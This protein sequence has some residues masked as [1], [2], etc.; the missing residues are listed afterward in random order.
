MLLGTTGV[1]QAE[2]LAELRAARR[3][4]VR[5]AIQA[6]TDA[7]APFG[8]LVIPVDFADARF[9]PGYDPAREL[10]PRLE[11][12]EPGSLAH[13][14]SVA[15]RGRTALAVR[16]AP[17]VSLPEARLAYSDLG[18]QG[19]SRTRAMAQQALAR[20]AALGADFAAADCDQDGEVD[21][22]L[23]LHAAPGL[24]NDPDGLIVP[25]QYFLAEPVVQQGIIA[26]S[27][28]VAAARSALGLWA[29]ETGHLLGLEDRYD[30]FFPSSSEAAPRGGLGSFSL[31]ASGWLGSGLGQDPALP[32]AY[33]CLLL[34]WVDL[35]AQPGPA[36]V[37]RLD[38]QD[39]PGPEFFLAEQRFVELTGPYDATLPAQRLLL[40]HIDER[41]AEGQ[42]S[43]YDHGWPDRHLRA[44]LVQ[45]D[46]S[47][48]V[49]LGVSQGQ[50]SDLFPTDGQAQAFNDLTVP[51]SRSFA[52][53]VTGVDF[54]VAL[55]QGQLV[56]CQ[57][58]ANWAADFR[59]CFVEEAGVKRAQAE[60]KL[61]SA[62]PWPDSLQVTI[63]C[64]DTTWGRFAG[65]P[66]ITAWLLRCAES[67]GQWAD[68]RDAGLPSW[69]PAAAVPDSALSVFSY[70]LP[71]GMAGS[72]QLIWPWRDA[73]AD[74]DL[75]GA[76]PG[77]W[78]ATYPTGDSNTRWHRWLDGPSAERIML[79]CTAAGATSGAAW[80]D[81]QYGNRAHAVLL[82][83]PLG[84]ATR[85]IELTHAVDLELQYPRLAID[86]VALTW[87]HANGRTVVPAVPADGWLGRVESR[88]WHALAGRPTFAVHDSLRA[89]GMPLWRREVLP[90]PA[91][92]E[93]GPGPWQLQLELASNALWRARGWLVRDLAAH[94]TEAPASGFPLWVQGEALYWSWRQG[95]ANAAF[96]LEASTDGGVT[97]I[98]C[99]EG[100]GEQTGARGW[101]LGNFAATPGMRTWLR[102]MAHDGDDT[103]VS[104]AI[105]HQTAR[106]PALGLPRPNPAHT[107]VHVACEGAGDATA[108]LGLYDMRGR[109]L[110]RWSPGEGLAVMSWDGTDDQGRPLPAGVYILR[111]Q[112]DN[113]QVSRK[114][115]WLP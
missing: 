45:A 84:A 68:F 35:G 74:L 102:V 66:V 33:S 70:T 12:G 97:W 89:T 83:P 86:G 7:P 5:A 109:R 82:S 43:S 78:Q 3:A 110:R 80:P 87:R 64:D 72:G 26:R 50:A 1:S 56:F 48:S 67:E 98:I 14:F 107:V 44:N 41:L 106:R 13:Y 113:Q 47:G 94:V 79:A 25:L 54:S 27:Y 63:T 62:A 10:L 75:A 4:A 112:A 30:P 76:W 115:T 60:L 29:H 51:D 114:V 55:E 15:S 2:T 71:P 21:G 92:A 100:L 93:H 42:A 37:V 17:R 40:L 28:A 52:G 6:K 73:G 23:L 53:L 49:A 88:A 57:Q 81:V 95:Q 36:T 16:L 91:A 34:G 108:M 46:G 61:H 32:D 90:V 111:L 38:F 11:G 31:M 65:G 96:S 9:A 69:L 103:I 58:A 8:L 39:G 105:A 85:W 24:E 20:A 22:V 101:P 77:V 99:A 18:W 59:L 19:F 104:R